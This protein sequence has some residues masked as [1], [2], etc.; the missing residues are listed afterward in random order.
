MN[1]K[2]GLRGSASTIVTETSTATGVGSGSVHVFAT[3]MLVA[4]ME[5]AA[6]NALEG[7]VPEGQTTVGTRVDIVHTAA[8]PVNITVTAYAELIEVDRKRLLFNVTAE[9]NAGPIGHGQHERF[10]IVPEKFMAKARIKLN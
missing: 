8:T 4:L 5:K 2:P 3:P 1:F 10:I 6:I 7:M 9:D